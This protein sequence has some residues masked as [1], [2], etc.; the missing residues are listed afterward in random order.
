MVLPILLLP[1]TQWSNATPPEP[2]ARN[3]PFHLSERAQRRSCPRR[4]QAAPLPY[5]AALLNHWRLVAVLC[6]PPALEPL[7]QT[8]R[9]SAGCRNLLAQCESLLRQL[10]RRRRDRLGLSGH[11]LARVALA[12]DGQTLRAPAGPTATIA[13]LLASMYWE[14]CRHPLS[15]FA[16]PLHPPTGLVRWLAGFTVQEQVERGR[17]LLILLAREEDRMFGFAHRLTAKIDGMTVSRNRGLVLLP[18]L[19]RLAEKPRINQRDSFT[20]HGHE[21][22]RT[23]ERTEIVLRAESG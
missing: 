6:A 15:L 19:L 4:Q 17:L 14:G 5:R 10:L 18:E 2:T 7:K 12:F 23:Y 1:A 16:S 13:F 11:D 21:E 8:S 9:S 22:S 20:T 3:R